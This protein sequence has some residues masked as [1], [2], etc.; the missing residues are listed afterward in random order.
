[1]E[2]NKR[3]DG[4]TVGERNHPMEEN[5]S[6]GMEQTE[7]VVT[8]PESG[9]AAEQSSEGEKSSGDAG[10]GQQSHEDNRRYQAA[11]RSGEE[12]GYQRAKRELDQRI[13]RM[14][15]RSPDGG[16]L[17][18]NIDGLEKFS[19]SVRK[20]RIAEKAKRE[21]RSEAEVEEEEANREFVSQ[22]RRQAAENQKVDAVRARQ[23]QW[24]AQDVKDFTQRFP[25]VDLG[26]LDSNKAFLRFCGSRYGKEPLGDL[27]EDYLE[28]TG[29]AATAATQKAESKSARAT[30]TGGGSGSEALTA[31]QQ[32]ELD[33]WNRTYPQMK[34]TAKEYLSR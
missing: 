8:P 9:E 17:I 26:K 25:D 27:Y 31:S 14:G 15:M 16:E 18:D 5:E 13:A 4:S 30:G 33:E 7:E 19:Q 20:Q 1:M 34:M 23:Q 12:A 6:L 29:G 11:R 10:R 28:I 2:T 3:A 21:G 22:S 32:R 24:I